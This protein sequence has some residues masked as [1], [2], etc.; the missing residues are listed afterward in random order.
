MDVDQFAFYVFFLVAATVF[1]NT[2]L[3]LRQRR[4]YDPGLRI[5]NARAR[6]RQGVSSAALL[7]ERELADRRQ[8]VV[9]ALARDA[10]ALS[11][12]AEAAE[13]DRLRRELESLREAF[14]AQRESVAR[15][16]ERIDREADE[17]LARYRRR[18]RTALACEVALLALSLAALVALVAA[19]AP[20]FR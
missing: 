8:R 19:A 13:E 5:R 14:E 17:E 20:Y 2:V 7:A 3:R 6:R 11:G 4:L 16:H 1:G 10:S 12:P 9:G 18:R 15:E